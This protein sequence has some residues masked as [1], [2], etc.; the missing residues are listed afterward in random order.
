MSEDSLTLRVRIEGRVQGVWYRGWTA[1]Q[2]A[3][4]HLTG[5]VRNCFDGSVEALLSGPPDAVYAMVAACR[6]GPP[7]ALVTSVA[8]EPA[9]P[10]I[11]PG[12][13]KLPSV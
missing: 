10:P 7:A 6:Q 13:H 11:S 8:T 9:P 3:A 5:W 12:F 2:A 4:R 1:E